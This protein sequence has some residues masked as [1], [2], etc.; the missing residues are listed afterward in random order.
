MYVKSYIKARVQKSYWSYL[1]SKWPKLA[2]IDTKM[3]K[4]T[5][6]FGAARTYIAHIRERLPPGIG[7]EVA[8]RGISLKRDNA[9]C[10]CKDIPNYMYYRSVAS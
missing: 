1:S 5:I 6:S 4:L 9:T 8:C 2:Y 7:L 10:I 3:A